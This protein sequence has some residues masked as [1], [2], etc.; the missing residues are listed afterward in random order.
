MK[1]NVTCSLDSELV[2]RLDAWRAGLGGHGR[3]RALEVL[4]QTLPE[5]KAPEPVAEPVAEVTDDTF[6][7]EAV[8]SDLGVFASGE[9]VPLADFEPAE[10]EVT[11][12]I[13]SPAHSKKPS[14]KH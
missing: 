6:L 5:P 10:E 2:A 1:T 4:L 3:S 13:P 8:R 9:T 14:K 12:Q 7:D 11:V